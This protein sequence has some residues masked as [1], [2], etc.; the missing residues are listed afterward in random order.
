[1]CARVLAE[2]PDPLSPNVPAEVAEVIQHSLSKQPDARYPD[3]G[4]FAQALRPFAP[5]EAQIV[6]DRVVRILKSPVAATSSSMAGADD[7]AALT[8][9][10]STV[11]ATATTFTATN[12][13]RKMTPGVLALMG[14]AGVLFLGTVVG[15]GYAAYR[16]LSG[17]PSGVAAAPESVAAPVAAAPATASAPASPRNTE[18]AATPPAESAQPPAAGSAAPAASAASKPAATQPKATRSGT[19]KKSSKD[20]FG[21]RD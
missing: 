11:A 3:I 20:A 1:V 7:I 17:R 19:R 21:G 8:K 14:L 9:S 6:A 12:H 13:T 15:G 2:S 5:L 10:A 16:F 18:P 4:V